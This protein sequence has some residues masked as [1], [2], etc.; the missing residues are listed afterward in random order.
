MGLIDDLAPGAVA[1]DT[2]PIIYYTENRAPY[3]DTVDLLVGL[4]EAGDRELVTSAI[5]L[6]EVLVVPFRRGDTA[7]AARYEA[8]LTRSRGIRLVEVERGQLRLAAELRARHGVRTP[9]ALQLSAAL[10]ARCGTFVTND[11]RLPPIP[12]LRVLQLDDYR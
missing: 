1:L 11:R 4:A 9:D 12:D 3:A 8:L 2:A 10:S 5:T 6:L 7:L